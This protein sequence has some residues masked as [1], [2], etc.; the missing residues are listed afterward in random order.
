MGGIEAGPRR[1]DVPDLHAAY[2]FHLNVNDPHRHLLDPSL[3]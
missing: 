1:T 2:F 3:P